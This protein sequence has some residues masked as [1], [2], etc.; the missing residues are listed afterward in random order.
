MIPYPPIYVQ[1]EYPAMRRRLNKNGFVDTGKVSA[2]GFDLLVIK[3]PFEHATEIAKPA[4]LE[5]DPQ[6]KP[7]A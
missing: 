4:V 3:H 7:A 1:T 6:R 5:Q 2:D